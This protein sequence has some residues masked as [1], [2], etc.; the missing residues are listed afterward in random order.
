MKHHWI[1]GKP[2][3]GG[4]RE[5]ARDSLYLDLVGKFVCKNCGWG[6]IVWWS[7]GDNVIAGYEVVYYFSPDGKRFE[8]PF[9]SFYLD[10]VD[11]FSCPPTK[12][13]IEKNKAQMAF[14]DRYQ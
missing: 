4:S 3:C 7:E 8:R 11:I 2:N 9:E 6:K 13:E 14:W 10:G 12:K 1:K 5:S